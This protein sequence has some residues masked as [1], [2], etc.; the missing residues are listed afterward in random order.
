LVVLLRSDRDLL[1]DD[2]RFAPEVMEEN[3]APVDL[4][5]RIAGICGRY[6]IEPADGPSGGAADTG[7][8]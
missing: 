6:A 3:Q 1:R 4:L 8:T 2:R 5:V 7:A